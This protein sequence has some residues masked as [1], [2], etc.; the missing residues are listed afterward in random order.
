MSTFDQGGGGYDAPLNM[1]S[2]SVEAAFSGG[3]AALKACYGGLLGA[4]VIYLGICLAIGL[5]CGFF[6]AITPPIGSCSNLLLSV[7][8]Q[9]PLGAGLYYIGVRAYRGEEPGP[10]ALFDGFGRYWT[11][12]GIGVLIGLIVFACM[13]PGLA[14]IIFGAVLTAMNEAAGIAVIIAGVAAIFV[15]MI[16]VSIRLA[17]SFQCCLDPANGGLGV[18]ESISTS[19]SMTAERVWPLFGLFLLL[20]LILIGTTLL[21]II[22]LVLLGAPLGLA[23]YGTAY[24]QI[25]EDFLRT[26]LPEVADSSVARW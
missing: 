26:N 13:I 16:Y 22:G 1:P 24:S 18:I 4:Y 7:F 2:F 25:R 12:V 10:G 9:G 5:F 8:V 20:I 15:P 6:D 23:V 3:W 21:L 11:V 17:F 14:V 19:W